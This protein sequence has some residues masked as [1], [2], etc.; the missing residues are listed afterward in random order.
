MTAAEL[1]GVFAGGNIRLVAGLAA[2]LPIVYNSVVQKVEYSE[3]R[4]RVN[5]AANSIEG[6]PALPLMAPQYLLSV[7]LSRSPSTGKLHERM[8][9]FKILLTCQAPSYLTIADL[10]ALGM[11]DPQCH[12]ADAVLV[13]VPLGVLKKG[14]L[15]F[16][17][18][19]PERKLGAIQ[20]M[21]FG[22]LNKVSMMDPAV[23]QII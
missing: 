8:S 6:E 11:E 12:A 2:G 21:G 19:L 18:P 5:T 20:R 17:P 3:D 14:T 1:F 10:K 22:T 4:V 15:K 23:L 7:N 9:K 13:T 16:D